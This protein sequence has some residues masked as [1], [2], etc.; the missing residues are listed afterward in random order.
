MR[1][2]KQIM[3]SKGVPFPIEEWP[4]VFLRGMEILNGNN[5]FPAVTLIVGSPGETD[6][7]VKA[8]LDL[9]YEVERRGLFAFFIP[10]IFTPLHDTRMEKKRGCARNAPAYAPAMAAH[11]EMLE[12]EPAP[13]QLLQLVGADGLAIGRRSDVAVEAAEAERAKLHVA[14]A[15]LRQR[16][17]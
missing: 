12:D 13:R 10:S 7:D 9:I 5:W 8:T 2:A 1:I 14:V 4:S 16:A 17:T 3:P 15:Q 11:D 6:D